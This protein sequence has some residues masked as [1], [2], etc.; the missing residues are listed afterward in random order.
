MRRWTGDW[1][2]W[3]DQMPSGTRA[4]TTKTGTDTHEIDIGGYFPDPDESVRIHIEE[5]WQ[6]AKF[7]N[8]QRPIWE[9]VVAASELIELVPITA[10]SV[11]EA[12][13]KIT[14]I[15]WHPGERVLKVRLY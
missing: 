5:L 13:R 6:H 4:E 15:A 11:E 2:D 9:M 1:F 10:K 8:A 12:R 7:T 3:S 14:V